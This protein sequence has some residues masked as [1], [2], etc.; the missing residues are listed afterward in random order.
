MGAV[1][2]S[3]KEG[4]TARERYVSPAVIQTDTLNGVLRRV[5]RPILAPSQMSFIA[6]ADDAQDAALFYAGD[7]S[8]LERPAIAVVGAREVSPEGAARA[9]R[10]SREAAEAGV[11]I[12]SGL[13]KGVD[14]NAHEAAIAA[15]GK[16]VAVIGT[17]LEKAYPAENG[18]LQSLIARD[19]LLISPF[20]AGQR[21]FQSNFPR[22]NKVMAA[23]T[24]GSV[25]IEASDTSG[26]LHQVAECQ[27][28]GRWLFI[29]RS[30][31]ENE[32]LSWPRSFSNYE[33]LKVVDSTA[34]VL[35]RVLR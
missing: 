21:V 35:D 20:P 27:R 19:H 5:G 32:A 6:S 9:R 7:L 29:L 15:G 25:I 3:H 13:A 18:P 30:V 17:P 26:T 1:A 28:L 31:Y 22:R 24:D 12:V 33:K 14:R 2:Y 4:S 34:D 23:L 16:T 10:I 8:L 11:T